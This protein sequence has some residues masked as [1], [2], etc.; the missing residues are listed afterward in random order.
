MAAL[1]RVPLRGEV[2]AAADLK[3]GETV[4]GKTAILPPAHR[5]KLYCAAAAGILGPDL[6]MR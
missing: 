2:F 1:A 3:I 6:L 4:P 5:N